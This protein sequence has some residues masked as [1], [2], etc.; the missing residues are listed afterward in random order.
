ML[1]VVLNGIGDSDDNVIQLN[2]GEMAAY[3]CEYDVHHVLRRE[4]GVL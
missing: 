4:R 2:S 3:G 1:K